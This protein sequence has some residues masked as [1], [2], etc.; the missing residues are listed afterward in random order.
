MKTH[1]FNIDIISN[2][3]FH[4]SPYHILK[5]KN[6]N[7]NCWR[8]RYFDFSDYESL[9][10]NYIIFSSHCLKFAAFINLN[11]LYRMCIINIS[12]VPVFNFAFSFYFSME[13]LQKKL[14]HSLFCFEFSILKKK[15]N[16][17]NMNMKK[18]SHSFYAWNARK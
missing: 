15:T 11:I 9:T 5:Q 8:L 13:K 3:F 17:K 12:R 18:I 10:K 7:Q 14:V 16:K 2:V 4:I 1:K 6:T